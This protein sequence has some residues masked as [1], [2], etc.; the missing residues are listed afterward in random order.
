MYLREHS[1]GLYSSVIHW[2]VS[3][4]PLLLLRTAQSA[5]YGFIL[6]YWMHLKGGGII[7]L[8]TISLSIY[9]SMYIVIDGV[10]VSTLLY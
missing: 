4:I 3:D 6:H 8:L 10:F 9:L 2:L 1:R 5:L 7:L